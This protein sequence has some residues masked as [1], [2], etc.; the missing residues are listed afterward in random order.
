MR[1][2]LKSFEEE[3]GIKVEMP[4]PNNF[5]DVQCSSSSSFFVCSGPD[6][7]K[8]YVNIVRSLKKKKE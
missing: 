6:K 7:I 8:L 3:I 1:L 4:D 2:P 5:A